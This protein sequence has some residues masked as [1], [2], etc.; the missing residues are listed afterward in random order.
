MNPLIW[1][2]V[3]VGSI[4]IIFIVLVRR[5]PVAARFVREEKKEVTPEKVMEVSLTAQADEAY[6]SKNYALAEELYIKLATEDPKNSK[7]Y[8]RLGNIYLNQQNFYDAKDAFL[9]SIKLDPSE[10]MRHVNLGHAYMGLKDYFK[11][12]QAFLQ[13]IELNPKENKFRQLYERAQKAL[14]REKKRGK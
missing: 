1:D 10:V 12:T 9:Q 6:N 7:L 5:L 8:D 11:A 4:V 13:A 2:G 3:I 14:E